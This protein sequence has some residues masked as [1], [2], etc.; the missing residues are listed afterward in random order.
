MVLPH[1]PEHTLGWN[2]EALEALITKESMIGV[3]RLEP[4]YAEA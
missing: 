4:P 2:V 1:R 3:A